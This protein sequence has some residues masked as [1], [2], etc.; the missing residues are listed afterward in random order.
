M[1]QNNNNN[2]ENR[3]VK[4]FKTIKEAFSFAWLCKG[5]SPKVRSNT[6][7]ND[8]YVSYILNQSTED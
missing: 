6:G 5:K 4:V 7:T 1:E 2:S 8:Y 3:V